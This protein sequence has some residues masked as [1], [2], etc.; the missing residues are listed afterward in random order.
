[1]RIIG[2]VDPKK[3]KEEAKKAEEK[4]KEKKPEGNK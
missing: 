2:W 4:A 3:A 1:M